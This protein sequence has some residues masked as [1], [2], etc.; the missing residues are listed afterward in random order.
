MRL[1][2]HEAEGMFLERFLGILEY[3]KLPILVVD[4]SRQLAML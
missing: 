2:M 4:A 3:I 1:G